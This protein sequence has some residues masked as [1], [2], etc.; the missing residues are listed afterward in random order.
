M[1]S[2]SILIAGIVASGV[3]ALPM[4][5]GNITWTFDD[6]SASSNGT[7]GITLS[8]NTNISGSFVFNADGGP[9]NNCSGNLGFN[10]SGCP[11]PP[12][13]GSFVSASLTVTPGSTLAGITGDS[14][15]WYI[16]Q[17]PNGVQ[18]GYDTTSD[19]ENIFLVDQNPLL[20]P[21][22]SDGTGS[23]AYVIVLNLQDL[24]TDLLPAY[25]QS[26]TS[27]GMVDSPGPITSPPDQSAPQFAQAGYCVNADCSEIDTSAGNP[28]NSVLYLTNTDD[29]IWAADPLGQAPGGPGTPEPGTFFLGGSVLLAVGMF[30]KR[31]LPRS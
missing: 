12:T 28:Y 10:P 23:G 20:N 1:R 15:A 22:L 30:R 13:I 18:N 6:T 29:H 3:M 31:I 27:I 24:M 9:T 8:D 2:L 11:P 26:Y 17:T 5:A 25:P 7:A 4:S 19:A 14:G 21:D 16:M